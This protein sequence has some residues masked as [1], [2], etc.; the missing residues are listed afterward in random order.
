MAKLRAATRRAAAALAIL[1]VAAI[2][3]GAAAG[4]AGAAT[5][6]VGTTCDKYMD[7]SY[8]V[9]YAAG[10]RERN[11]VRIVR[12]GETLSVSDAGALIAAPA[13]CAG[14]GSHDITCTFDLAVKRIDVHAGD[15]DD[16]IDAS[17]VG[18]G[19]TTILDGGPGNDVVIGSP[20]GDSLAG[21]TG[22]DVLDGRGGADVASYADHRLAV[23][24]DLSDG[25]AASAA[26]EHDTLIAIEQ[27]R[28]GAG[29]DLLTGD[30]GANV[31]SGGGGDD[32][33]RGGGGADYLKGDGRL[34]GGSGDDRIRLLHHGRASCGAGRADSVSGSSQ[35]VVVD[36]SC[37]HLRLPGIA[38]ELDLAHHDRARNAIVVPTRDLPRPAMLGVRL[39]AARSGISIGSLHRRITCEAHCPD[40]RLRFGANALARIGRRSSLDVVLI[41]QARWS[42]TFGGSVRLRI[43]RH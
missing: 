8:V 10:P 21:G 37:E 15:G 28:G 20:L 39:I 4:S 1:F 40:V 33:M 13:G 7:C 32:V 36:D 3:S 24:A 30:A 29:D 16:G 42:R 6:E 2:A 26:G 41:V 18:D 12:A 14:G 5:L 9:V 31:L 35:R 23:R 11:L 25:T 19:T 17:A 27:L 38:V 34:D 22:N 43:G